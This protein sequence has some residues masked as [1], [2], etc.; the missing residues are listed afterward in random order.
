LTFIHRDTKSF[1]R[2]TDGK[3]FFTTATPAT[4]WSTTPREVSAQDLV[5][6]RAEKEA[7]LKGFSEDGTRNGPTGTALRLKK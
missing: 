3:I 7:L 2:I 5:R 6:A 1:I 4:N